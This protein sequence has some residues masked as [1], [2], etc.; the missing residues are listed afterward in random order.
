QAVVMAAAHT[1]D[2]PIPDDSRPLV[3]EE[4]DRLPE[5]YRAVVVLCY[6]EGKTHEEAAAQ[7]GWPLGSVKGRLA[8]ARDLLRDRLARRGLARSAAGLGTALAQSA[9][10]AAVPLALLKV[11]L[12]AAIS[13]AGGSA[14][15]APASAQALAKGALQAMTRTKLVYAIFATVA[16]CALGIGA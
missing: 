12:E 13:F 9:G 7:L 16:L 15:A 8:R 1:V 4:V 3:H 14:A 5:K 10:T 6:L 2:D 11:T